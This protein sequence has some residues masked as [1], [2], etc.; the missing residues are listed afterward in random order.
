MIIHRSFVSYRILDDNLW[1]SGMPRERCL[2]RPPDV[3]LQAAWADFSGVNIRCHAQIKWSLLRHV[4]S[5][6]SEEAGNGE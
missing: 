6:D 3:N 5:C 4:L 2:Y 1:D